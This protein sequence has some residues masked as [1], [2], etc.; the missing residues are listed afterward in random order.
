VL[1]LLVRIFLLLQLVFFCLSF[2]PVFRR[3]HLLLLALYS[4]GFRCFC[5]RVL[6]KESSFGLQFRLVGKRN[7]LFESLLCLG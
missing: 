5:R 4:R 1:F 3:P 6:R 7:L 2:L